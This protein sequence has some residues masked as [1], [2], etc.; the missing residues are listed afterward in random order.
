MSAHKEVS[1]CTRAGE[2]ENSHHDLSRNAAK[3][4]GTA[5][6]GYNLDDAAGQMG[7]HEINWSKEGGKGIISSKPLERI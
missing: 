1:F 2:R 5:A 4:I 3:G 7:G 6:D